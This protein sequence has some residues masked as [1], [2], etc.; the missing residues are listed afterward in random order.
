MAVVDLF[1]FTVVHNILNILSPTK[2]Y[3]TIILEH[4]WQITLEPQ[5]HKPYAPFLGYLAV[6]KDLFGLEF[7]KFKKRFLVVGA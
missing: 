5:M 6:H 7:L 3:R 2:S 4:K 1:E